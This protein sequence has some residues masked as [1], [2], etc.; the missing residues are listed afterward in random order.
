MSSGPKNPAASLHR[1]DVW[2]SPITEIQ[3]AF[4]DAAADFGKLMWF[5]EVLLSPCGYIEHCSMAVSYAMLSK[6]SK[7]K[8]IQ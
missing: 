5:Y 1:I 8:H 2:L 6:G 3:V 4:L 7:V